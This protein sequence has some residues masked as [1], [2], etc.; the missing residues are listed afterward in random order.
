MITVT[1]N[2]GTYMAKRGKERSDLVERL[3]VLGSVIF[4]AVCGLVLTAVA[5]WGSWGW[6]FSLAGAVVL[7]LLFLFWPYITSLVSSKFRH[8]PKRALE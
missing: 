8:K 1:E 5:F 3:K 6:V 2:T 4:F 7:V